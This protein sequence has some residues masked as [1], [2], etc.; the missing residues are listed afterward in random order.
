MS[1][2]DDPWS[3]RRAYRPQPSGKAGKNG[4]E[5]GDIIAGAAD[6]TASMTDETRDAGKA[7]AGVRKGQDFNA[8]R[9]HELGL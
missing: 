9:A 4:M 8:R 5:M 7:A 1:A 6:F 3:F 2:I